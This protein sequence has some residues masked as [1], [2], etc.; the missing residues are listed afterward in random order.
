[1][2][3]RGHGKP[4]FGQN[5]SSSDVLH[6]PHFISLNKTD[7]SCLTCWHH[8]TNGCFQ[9]SLC[10]IP[11]SWYSRSEPPLVNITIQDSSDRKDKLY[12]A[13][14][15]IR[16]RVTCF[17]V[18]CTISTKPRVLSIVENPVRVYMTDHNTYLTYS[19]LYC[20]LCNGVRLDDLT[21]WST[22]IT[23]T[24]DLVNSLETKPTVAQL[25]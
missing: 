8:L 14:P 10:S 5:A 17:K 15:W 6:S 3:V 4:A 23:C 22:E 18:E 24:N 1:M 9:N 16:T 7:A 11:K 20:A 19:N 2:A 12:D 21:P 13:Q 25:M